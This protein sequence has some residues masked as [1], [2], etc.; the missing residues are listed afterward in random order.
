MAFTPK[1]QLCAFQEDLHNTIGQAAEMGS[2][3]VVMWGNRRDENTSPEICYKLNNYIR[4]KLGPYFES[5]KHTSEVCSTRK[6][7]GRGWCISKQALNENWGFSDSSPQ[8]SC[9]GPI[10]DFTDTTLSGKSHKENILDHA[11]VSVNKTDFN[12]DARN[13]SVVQFVSTKTIGH[14][15]VTSLDNSSSSTGNHKSDVATSEKDAVEGITVVETDEL[16]VTA[17]AAQLRKGM[18]S[19]GVHYEDEYTNR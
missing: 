11:S 10:R 15:L 9:P 13:S 17:S 14:T 12:T 2:S 7:S 18:T 16:S 5:V 6:C 4:T 8:E 1:F 3:G 19:G